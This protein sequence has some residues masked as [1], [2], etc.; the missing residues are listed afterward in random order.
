MCAKSSEFLRIKY[1]TGGTGQNTTFVDQGSTPDLTMIT[2]INSLQILTANRATQKLSFHASKVLITQQILILRSVC[3]YGFKA[4]YRVR[5]ARVQISHKINTSNSK[6]MIKVSKVSI[7]IC[8]PALK[9]S[10]KKNNYFTVKSGFE[11][12]STNVVFWLVPQVKGS[13]D[14]ETPG[15][16]ILGPLGF[17]SHWD[18]LREKT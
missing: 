7:W 2:L 4:G 8:L 14:A 12:W 17:R 11:P 9:I 6:R 10:I 15:L 1:L 18:L 13:K 5:K 3:A 16:L